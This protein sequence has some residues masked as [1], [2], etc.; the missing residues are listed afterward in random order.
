MGVLVV[1]E[2]LEC[3]QQVT[4]EHCRLGDVEDFQH[5]NDGCFP[6][7]AVDVLKRTLHGRLEVLDHIQE[8]ERTQRT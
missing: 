2:P 8:V 6:H 1:D 7:I 5:P 3:W 4:L